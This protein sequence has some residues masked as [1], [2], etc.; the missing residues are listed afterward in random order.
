M[1]DDS[2]EIFSVRL[3][4]QIAVFLFGLTISSFGL[5]QLFNSDSQISNE[6]TESMTQV[7]D[8]DL[9]FGRLTVDIGGAI[10]SPGVYELDTGSRMNDLISTAG[11][12]SSNVDKHY[13]NKVLNL[14]Q[15]LSDGEK[16]YIPT[17]QESLETLGNS[18][19]EPSG[20]GSSPD[21]GG[22]TGIISINS[23]S[24]NQLTG[25]VGIGEK[26]AG[27]IIAGRPYES[28]NQLVE[29]GI[30]TESIFEKI[31]NDISL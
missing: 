18:S 9:E 15:R 27:D 20:D 22:S 4:I 7:C 12:F 13:I 25:L 24:E 1:F 14:S 29:K 16:F 23:G 11:G 31:K 26:R 28:S 8:K 21:G 3:L 30:I 5:F 19:D 6:N 10:E 2:S 17:I